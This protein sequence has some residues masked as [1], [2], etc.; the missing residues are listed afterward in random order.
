M[1]TLINRLLLYIGC[2]LLSIFVHPLLV[3]RAMR[4]NNTDVDVE[5]L[6][7]SSKLPAS[8]L[9]SRSK[10]RKSNDN[11]TQMIYMYDPTDP[12]HR[13]FLLL[14]DKEDKKVNESKSIVN[15]F[16]D[17]MEWCLENSRIYN[18]GDTKRVL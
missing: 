4:M 7:F 9:T 10:L 18:Y 17:G 5:I 2:F 12:D 1:G 8:D 13:I 16:N 15:T 6:A 14:Y 3:F 11:Y